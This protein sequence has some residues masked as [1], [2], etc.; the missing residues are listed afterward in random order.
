MYIPVGDVGVDVSTSQLIM[1]SQ[2]STLE[3]RVA[4]T[5]TYG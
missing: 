5:T 4:E 3:G 1:A 2:C